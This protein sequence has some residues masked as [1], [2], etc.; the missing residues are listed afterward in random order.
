LPFGNGAER[1][2]RNQQVGGHFANINFNVHTNAHLFRGMLEG[3]VYSLRYGIEVMEEMGMKPKVIRA[4]HANLFFSEVFR[5]ALAT[6]AN[7]QIE[8]YQTD[9]AQGAARGAAI[10]IGALD[11]DS[12]FQG[13]EKIK[14]IEP[15]LAS[16]A[17]YE[18]AYQ[19]W[20]RLL[21]VRLKYGG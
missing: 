8:L 15:D 1:V 11:T 20:K 21:E 4:G 14:E 18:A 5:T 19:K 7:T 9:G 10:G 13:L 16:Q 6:C 12:A 2:L 17:A 3:I